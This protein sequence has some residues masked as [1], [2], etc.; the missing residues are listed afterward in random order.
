MSSAINSGGGAGI[1]PGAPIIWPSSKS[2]SE[3]V[4]QSQNTAQ[5]G[6]VK[7]SQAPQAA[8]SS[9]PSEAEQAAK[10]IAQQQLA[11]IAR[12]VNMQDLMSQLMQA[13]IRPTAANKQMAL[14][15][16]QQGLEL[17]PENFAKLARLNN[18]NSPQGLSATILSVLKGLDGNPNSITM[19]SEFLQQNSNVAQQNTQIQQ[20]LQNFMASLLNGKGLLPP[21][22]AGQLAG[23]AGKWDKIFQSVPGKDQSI[24]MFS[25]EAILSDIQGF[26]SLLNGTLQQLKQSAD[27]DSSQVQA[28]LR[29]ISQ[30]EEEI[31][32][33]LKNFT[34]QAM[35]SQ[36][37]V[38]PDPAMPEQFAYWLLPNF[39][40]TPPS[41]LEIVIQ[42]DS[43]SKKN[44]IDPNKTTIIMKLQTDA[45]GEIAVEMKVDDR[46]L[47]VR[48]N[49][50]YEETQKQIQAHM[51]EFKERVEAQ[52]FKIKTVHVRKKILDLKKLLVPLI[53]L[54][55][56]SRV[57]TQA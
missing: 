24:E 5:T 28:L 36:S 38:K 32:Q 18:S 15:M 19:L 46:N 45:L 13:N 20:S 56:L 12:K 51:K 41:D 31:A 22:L 16:L 25:K 30:L 55:E 2:E 44:I 8:A 17:S 52:D 54:D 57:R 3:A 33:M 53:D 29:Q 4:E 1:H 21:A 40:S 7:S 6:G 34:S 26:R 23:L 37:N 50:E 14:Q 9:T 43:K 39:L 47:S 49:A 35:V 11:T 42:K 10:Q 27:P 48:F